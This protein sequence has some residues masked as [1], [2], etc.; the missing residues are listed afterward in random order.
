VNRRRQ[1]IG[2]FADL[3]RLG[4]ELTVNCDS[5]RHRAVVSVPAL[6][7]RLGDNYRVQAFIERSICSKCGARWPKLSVTVTPERSVG[8]RRD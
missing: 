2:S 8:Y 3:I 7:T 5:C 1:L 4:H 6:A